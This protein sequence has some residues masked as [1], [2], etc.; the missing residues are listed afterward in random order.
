MSQVRSRSVQ[1][2]LANLRG[3]AARTPKQNETEQ[4]EERL[5]V[6]GKML[7]ATAG[8]ACVFCIVFA[9]PNH[10]VK[11]GAT[12]VRR[13][14]SFRI[15]RD[16]PHAEAVKPALRPAGVLAVEAL[17]GNKQ[18]PF[19]CYSCRACLHPVH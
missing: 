13:R 17:W 10:A 8:T 16:R 1:Q 19:R 5:R 15:W 9:E 7:R 12:P 14:A 3:F 6:T 11:L 4:S 18:A 2:D